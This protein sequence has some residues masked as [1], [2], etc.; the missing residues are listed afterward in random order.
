[1]VLLMVGPGTFSEIEHGAD[2]PG[3]GAYEQR[4]RDCPP[5]AVNG[6]T[7]D[8]GSRKLQEQSIDDEKKKPEGYDDEWYREKHKDRSDDGIDEAEYQG[9][10][11]SCSET[12]DMNPLENVGGCVNRKGID[13][14]VDQNA[15]DRYLLFMCVFTDAM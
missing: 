4:T 7:V 3:N 8:H 10:K 15:H 12:S 2:G 6:K 9:N 14:P 1:M 11:E 5:E 13:K